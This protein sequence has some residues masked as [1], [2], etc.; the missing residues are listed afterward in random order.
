MENKKTLSNIFVH[1]MIFVIITSFSVFSVYAAQSA[2]NLGTAENFV[3]LSKSGISTTGTTSIIGD[4]GV[5]PAAATYITGF[6]LIMD[7]SNQFA[8][9]SLVTGKIYA[10]DYTTPTPVYLNTAIRDMETAYTDAKG[11]VNPD[12]TELGAGDISGMTINPGLYKWGTGVLINTGVTLDC[13][14]NQDSIF[15]FQI[16]QD[17]NV[18]N[19]AIVTLKNGCQE[20]NIFWQVAG[21]VTLGTTSNF[22]GNILSKTLV[23]IKT[24]AILNG[25]ALAQTEVTLDANAV[26]IPPKS[27]TSISTSVVNSKLNIDTNLDLNDDESK[28]INE[29]SNSVVNTLQCTEWS[30]CNFEGIRTK[31]CTKPNS[32]TVSTETQSCTSIKSDST[33]NNQINLGIG[34]DLNVQIETAKK[35]INSGE[36]IMPLGQLLRVRELSQNLRELRVNNISIITNLNITS[37]IDSNGKTIIKT[38]LNNGDEQ[39]IKI[40]PDIASNKALESLRLK[41]CSLDKNCTIQLKDVGTG[42]QERVQYEVRLERQSKILGLFSNKMPVSVDVDAETG[43]TVVHKPWWAFIAIEPAE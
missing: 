20:N 12:V 34:Q 4:L 31:T 7:S 43:N 15:I 17:L 30:V 36:Y 26:T 21:Q 2:V 41:V 38:K 3:I 35:E 6:G 27:I 37:E 23:E 28:I 40:M 32:N 39:E 16:A 10:A 5:S 11:R 24:G 1:L 29:E 33:E 22:K 13:Q 18:G 25:R 42:T 9:S 19:G 8:S 14:N